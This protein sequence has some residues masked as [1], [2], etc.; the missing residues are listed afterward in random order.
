MRQGIFFVK[1]ILLINE[2]GEQRWL[3]E[4]TNGSIWH[5]EEEFFASETEAIKKGWKVDA[6]KLLFGTTDGKEGEGSQ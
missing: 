2:D 3:D 4:K 5:G 6:V 1:K